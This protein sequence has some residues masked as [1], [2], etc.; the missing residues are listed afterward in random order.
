MGLR[1]DVHFFNVVLKS[2]LRVRSTRS[3]PRIVG[4]K[5]V[6]R[7]HGV[8]RSS[9]GTVQSRKQQFERNDRKGH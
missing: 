7:A 2:I 5:R 6:S 1:L 8:G 4:F 3:S 9:E